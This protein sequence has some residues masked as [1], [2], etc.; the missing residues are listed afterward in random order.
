[1]PPCLGHCHSRAPDWCNDYGQ[2]VYDR[3]LHGRPV[4]VATTLPTLSG[5]IG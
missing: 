5:G 3:S 1:M 4:L 2:S